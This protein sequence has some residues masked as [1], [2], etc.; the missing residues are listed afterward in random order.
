MK[1][2]IDYGTAP[3]M[4]ENDCAGVLGRVTFEHYHP[5]L[6]C[7]SVLVVLGCVVFSEKPHL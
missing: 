1:R 4:S 7:F 3:M 6:P 5:P 2:E